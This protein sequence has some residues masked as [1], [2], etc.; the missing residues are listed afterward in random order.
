[1]H[2]ITISV[3]LSSFFI[4]IF[5]NYLSIVIVVFHSY[6]FPYDQT[7]TDKMYQSIYRELLLYLLIFTGIG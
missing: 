4:D 6:P 5:T 3:I 7:Q 2:F 1:M